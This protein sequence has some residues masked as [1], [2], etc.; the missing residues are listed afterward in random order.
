MQSYSI[1]LSSASHVNYNS[2]AILYFINFNFLNSKILG[3]CKQ[4]SSV[5]FLNTFNM[6]RTASRKIS[7][8][9]LHLITIVIYTYD[10]AVE[11]YKA[12]V[13]MNCFI[14]PCD[15]FKC[16]YDIIVAQRKNP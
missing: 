16:L 10:V 8:I 12:I 15:R 3:P 9:I 6:I 13:S 4:F 5:F 14:L 1:K 2:F 11:A 7:P